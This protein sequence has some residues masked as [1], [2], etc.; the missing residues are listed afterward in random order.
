MMFQDLVMETCIGDQTGTAAGHIVSNC[1]EFGRL[2][3]IYIYS[4]Y[5]LS[6][7]S[8][9]GTYN[10]PLTSPNRNGYSAYYYFYYFYMSDNA[11]HYINQRIAAIV[12]DP[13]GMNNS[14]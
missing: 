13:S 3:I 8:V 4:F 2:I 12:P 9:N 14:S 6:G 7:T 10:Y 5:L 11:G 1:C